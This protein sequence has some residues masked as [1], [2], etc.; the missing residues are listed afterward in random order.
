MQDFP[1]ECVARLQG[2]IRRRI[3][4]RDV[5]K[6]LWT[7]EVKRGGINGLYFDKGWPQFYEEN[8]LEAWD[9][10]AFEHKGGDL[11]NF[12]LYGRDGCEKKGVGGPKFRV[13]EEAEEIADDDDDEDYVVEELE[14]EEIK[15]I[16]KSNKGLSSFN[17]CK[18]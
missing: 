17:A 3:T 4:L 2:I 7:V 16:S 8:S 15:N 10:V 13:K 1:P 9:V 14:D 11:F 6:N 12:K 18:F 5:D